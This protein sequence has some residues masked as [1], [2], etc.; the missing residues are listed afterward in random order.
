M[1][2]PN[3]DPSNFLPS[4]EDILSQI[5]SEDFMSIPSSG[6][7]IGDP[8]FLSRFRA[9]PT[10]VDALPP[11]DRDP[12]M[13][14][15]NQLPE[16]IRDEKE[17]ELVQGRHLELARAARIRRGPAA[18]HNAVFEEQS[19][20]AAEVRQLQRETQRIMEELA[21]VAKRDLQTGAATLKHPK[22]S[23][24]YNDLDNALQLAL[25]KIDSLSGGDEAQRRIGKARQVELERRK[26]RLTE[27]YIAQE[28]TRRAEAKLIDE[29]IESLAS[30]RANLG[31]SAV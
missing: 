1:T 23:K 18:G 4:D 21:V 30:S 7:V 13:A 24:T 12:I 15:V 9:L 5:D 10:K 26:A 25:S 11:E 19:S 20:L 29:R 6:T 27:A 28:A 22:G 16:S 8:F 31:R 17:A 3:S 14:Q 2:D